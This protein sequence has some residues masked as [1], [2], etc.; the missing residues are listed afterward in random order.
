MMTNWNPIETAPKDGST[1]VALTKHNLPCTMYYSKLER[2]FRRRVT[3]KGCAA[4]D[5]EDKL[6][7]MP[8]PNSPIT[9]ERI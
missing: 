8:L 3:C 2:E 4:T 7:W 5:L 9:N 1:F 6:Y